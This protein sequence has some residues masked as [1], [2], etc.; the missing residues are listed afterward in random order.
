MIGKSSIVFYNKPQ[1]T[2]YSPHIIHSKF[3]KQ[4]VETLRLFSFKNVFFVFFSGVGFKQGQTVLHAVT[5]GSKLKTPDLQKLK[6]LS[7]YS[8]L[9]EIEF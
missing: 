4:K 9:S 1:I 3:L 7:K 2:S 5:F 6:H 8:K